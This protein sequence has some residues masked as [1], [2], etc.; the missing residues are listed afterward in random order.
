MT[1][2]RCV[3]GVVLAIACAVTS[4]A[5]VA[6]AQSLTV[7]SAGGAVQDAQRTAWYGP[8]TKQTGTKI[9]EDNWN[10]ELAKARAQVETKSI[11]WDVVEMTAINLSTACEEGLVERIDWAKYVNPKDFEDVGG[12]P[13]CGVPNLNASGGLAYDADRLKEAPKS[14]SDFWNVKK[15]PG[16]RGMLYRAEQT[17]EVALMAD[18]VAPKDVMTVLAGP[19][20]VDRAFKKLDELKPHIHWWKSGAESTQ[21]LASGEVAMAYAWNGRIAAANKNDKR[22]LRIAF[23]AGFVNGNNSLAVMKG[24]PNRELAIKFIQFASTAKAQAEFAEIIQYGPPNR[25]ALDLMDAKA[26]ATI[27]S[28]AIMKHAMFQHGTPYV[29]FWLDN[30]ARLL[31]RFG[32]WAAK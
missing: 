23:E 14:W 13:P 20:G 9:V 22:N 12:L 3:L 11:K 7:C 8:F 18:G 2:G 30:G 28:G 25:N 16:K 15:W 1:N 17:L 27:P 31:E 29:S 4:A 10:Q 21:L 5:P 6:L 26:K 19:G 32:Q 24:S